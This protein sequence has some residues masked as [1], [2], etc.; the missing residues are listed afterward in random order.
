MHPRSGTTLGGT[1][2]YIKGANLDHSF[3][4]LYCKFG[5][6]KVVAAVIERGNIVKCVSPASGF[7]TSQEVEV[8]VSVDDIYYYGGINGTQIQFFYQAPP[9][10]TSITPLRQS[11]WGEI[12]IQVNG[13][14][15]PYPSDIICRF[16]FSTTSSIVDIAGV[17][18]SSTS[19]FCTCPRHLIFDPNI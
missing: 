6:V 19:F 8:Q 11:M 9:V 14:G 2:V 15:F 10:F 13:S 1:E 4:G 17:P 18:S 3:G 12:P 16:K 7:L 5:T